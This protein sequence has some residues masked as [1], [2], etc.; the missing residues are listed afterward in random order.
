MINA[1]PN[2]TALMV[3]GFYGGDSWR[4]HNQGRRG[5]LMGC[6]IHVINGNIFLY[7]KSININL[8][9]QNVLPKGRINATSSFAFFAFAFFFAA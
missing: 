6:L 7:M 5:G 9:S 2:G 4:E 1:V 8:A 3:A